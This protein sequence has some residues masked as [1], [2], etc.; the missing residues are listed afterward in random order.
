MEN[1]QRPPRSSGGDNRNR[2]PRSNRPDQR[3]NKRDP[4]VDSLVHRIKDELLDSIEP[5]IIPELNAFQRK[6]V[7]RHFDH[8]PDIV[9]KTYRVNDEDYELRVYPVGNLRNWAKRKANEAV[10]NR[11]TVVLPHMSSYERFVVHDTLKSIDTVKAT[12]HGDGEERHIEI[13]PAIFGRGLKRIIKKIRL[14]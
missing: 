3:N 12:S 8:N 10:D 4:K 13:E 9:T 14:F 7:H 6:L 5:I 1:R 2:R 11:E